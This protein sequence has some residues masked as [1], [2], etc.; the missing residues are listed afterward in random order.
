MESFGEI[1]AM[2][3][4]FNDPL[5]VKQRAVLM[6]STEPVEKSVEIRPLKV[7]S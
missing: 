7:T 2:T 4:L 5:P 1:C 3:F 6:I